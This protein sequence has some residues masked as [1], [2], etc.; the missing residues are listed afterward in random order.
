MA[1]LSKSMRSALGAFDKAA[2]EYGKNSYPAHSM[3]HQEYLDA[4]SKL[5]SLILQ[6]QQRLK[7]VQAELQ[8]VEHL[9]DELDD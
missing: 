1:N 5:E 7:S 2:I 4:R 3:G 8:R 9:L 6:Q